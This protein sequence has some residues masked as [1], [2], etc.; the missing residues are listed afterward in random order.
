MD[1]PLQIRSGSFNTAR[2]DKLTLYRALIVAG[3]PDRAGHSI[4]LRCI[5]DIGAPLSVV[6]YDIWKRNDLPWTSVSSSLSTAAGS[7]ALLWEGVPCDLGTMEID[8][9]G[10]RK[11]M[12]KFALQPTRP[13]EVL[14]G[15]SFLT[16]NDIELVLSGAAGSLSGFLS[17]P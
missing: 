8:L 15:V 7:S 5:L 12:A 10:R 17:L 16:D 9:A 4:P 1:I 3:F 13:A 14:L 11:L 6:P 2:G